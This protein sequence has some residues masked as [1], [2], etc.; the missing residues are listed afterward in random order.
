MATKV[1]RSC[2]ISKELEYFPKNMASSDGFYSLCKLCKN[3]KN[4]LYKKK[5]TNEEKIRNK[6]WYLFNSE[7][8]LQR[9]NYRYKNDIKFKIATTLRSRLYHAINNNQKV[10][11]AID[12]LG[13]SVKELKLYLESQFQEGMTWDNWSKYGWHIDH[14]KPLSSFD[15]SDPEQFKKA[16]HYSNLQPLWAEDN[17][18]KSNKY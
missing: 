17:L 11:S 16:C 12:N 5:H 9:V 15:L 4:S 18:K 8:K 13:C 6:R 2:N 3:Y 7:R 10:G 14:I 1:C